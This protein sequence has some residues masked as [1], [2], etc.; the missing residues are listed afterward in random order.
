[1]LFSLSSNCWLCRLLSLLN[2]D[3]HEA[4]D[5]SSTDWALVSL[6]PND[7]RALNAE[8][9]VSTWQDNC[10]LGRGEADHTLSLGVIRDVGGCVI[11]AIDVTQ[12][13]DSIVVLKV[14]EIVSCQEAYKE[15]LF[16]EL[17]LQVAWRILSELAVGYLY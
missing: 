14:K 9:H 2:F 6:H 3:L 4:G 15:L 11:Y 10:V 7:L 8:T 13:K 1:M 16:E 5:L 12:V 17:V